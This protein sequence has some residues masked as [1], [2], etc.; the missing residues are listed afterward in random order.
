MQIPE[1]HYRVPW[2]T[3]NSYPGHHRSTQ[4]GA[5]IEFRQHTTLLNAPDPRRFDIRASLRDPFNQILVRLYT[6][7]S[8]IP[9]YAVA[10]LSASMDFTGQQ[11][12]LDVLADFIACLGYSAYR[13]GDLF[14]FVGFDSDVVPSFLQ[15][16]TRNKVA[17]PDLAQRLRHFTP[18]GQD[19]AGLLKATR[20]IKQ[21]RSLVFLISDFHLPLSL[22]E[23]ALSQLAYHTVI[24]VI[25]W[26]RAEYER[27]P[28]FGFV[29]VIDYETQ[30]QRS[31]LLRPSV[32]AR[33]QQHWQQRRDQ[34]NVMLAKHGCRPLL[35]TDRF[36]PDDVTAY[37]FHAA[38]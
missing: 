32:R 27:L 26:D 29:R 35:L 31:L 33:I 19:S 21:Q 16:L 2:R 12:K 28:K 18:T 22:L 10:D 4:R 38:P 13:T 36:N 6:Q 1:F 25:L 8:S 20:L 30:E 24:P 3:R 14:S 23:Q 7:T 15:P 17:G 9:I 34:I 11:R 5:G 37:F